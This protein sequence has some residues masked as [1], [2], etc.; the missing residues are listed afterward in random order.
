MRATSV[1]ARLTLAA[2]L[3][4]SLGAC[5]VRGRAWVST[6]GVVVVEEQP[7][8]P[9]HEV[10]VVRAGYIWID[11]HWERHGNQWVWRDG[12]Y[13]RQR[14]DADWVPGRWERR[15]RGHVWVQGTWRVRGG[16]HHHGD[17]HNQDHRH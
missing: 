17:P 8:P 3:A 2:V 7:P 16:G 13:E 11:G 1:I 4:T 14:A 12:Y 9:R 5:V 10:I 6:P 15:G